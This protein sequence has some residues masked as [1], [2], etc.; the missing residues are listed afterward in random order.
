MK[1][2]QDSIPAFVE[3]HYYPDGQKYYHVSLTDGRPAWAPPSKDVGF[4]QEDNIA[5]NQHDLVVEFERRLVLEKR[6]TWC[7]V[8]SRSTDETTGD[9]RQHAGVGIWLY[10]YHITDFEYI[11][12]CLCQLL[13][14]VATG[15]DKV[16]FEQLSASFLRLN[17]PGRVQVASEYPD[18]LD[19]IPFAKAAS[20]TQFVIDCKLAG[21]DEK[22]KVA[23]DHLIYLSFVPDVGTYSRA[24][25]HIPVG[26]ELPASNK[27]VHIID[28]HHNYLSKLVSSIPKASGNVASKVASLEADLKDAQNQNVEL[29]AGLVEKNEEVNQLETKAAALQSEIDASVQTGVSIPI[30]NQFNLLKKNLNLFEQNIVAEVQKL[31]VSLPRPQPTKQFSPSEKRGQA[32]PYVNKIQ[33]SGTANKYVPKPYGDRPKNPMSFWLLLVLTAFVI[34]CSIG[35]FV[36]LMYF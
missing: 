31:A 12:N 35:I 36:W 16:R 32:S 24:L 26:T 17:L 30:L 10:E 25:I 22:I 21:I 3:A 1:N 19:G 8:Y 27:S 18:F 2:S 15:F 7:A 5:L 20:S 34:A 28:K 6:L 11:I 14:A 13:D 23:A 4:S 9:R 29:Q 33:T